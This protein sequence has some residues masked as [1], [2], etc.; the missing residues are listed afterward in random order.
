MMYNKKNQ[1]ERSSTM[2]IVGAVA[3]VGLVV[4]LTGCGVITDGTV[5][6]RKSWGHI[7]D[8]PVTSG[9]TLDIPVIYSI[10][11]WDIKTREMKEQAS[12]PSSEGLV[13]T[14]DVSVIYSIAP[15][16]APAIR[17]TWGDQEAVV[18]NILEPYTRE[19]IRLVI[20]GSPVK[21]QY[22]EEGRQKLSIDMKKHLVEKI[23]EKIMIIDV[24]LRDVKLPPTFTASIES[25]LQAEQQALQQEFELQKAV[26]K[27]EIAVAEAKGVSEANKIIADSITENY[28]RYSWIQNMKNAEFQVVY[29]PTEAG[30]P[31]LEAGKRPQAFKPHVENTSVK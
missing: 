27:A 30:L 2:R 13:S 1:N 10:D 22:S 28:L 23:G 25:K 11:K 15:D 20:S 26:K 21:A 3:V 18:S 17:K 9:L 29:I 5:G 6:V 16:K 24:L 8:Y 14:L 7:S 12:V 4:C 31:I 19:S